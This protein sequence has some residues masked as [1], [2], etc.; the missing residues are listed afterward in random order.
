MRLNLFISI[1][2]IIASTFTALHEIKHLQNH[3]SSSCPICIV[4]D[5]SISADI[6]DEFKEIYIFNFDEISSLTSICIIDNKK[7]YHQTRAPPQKS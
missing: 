2:F 5:H 4:D 3:N 6:I 7:Y 1:F